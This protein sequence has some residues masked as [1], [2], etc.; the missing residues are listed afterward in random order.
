MRHPKAKEYAKTY[1]LKHKDKVKQKSKE[2][3]ERN[4][5]AYNLYKQ[6]NRS[7]K[8]LLMIERFSNKCN[9]CQQSFPPCVYDFHHFDPSQ[10]DINIGNKMGWSLKRLMKELDKCIMLCA[11]CH[12]IRHNESTD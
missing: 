11:N 1:Y 4:K 6:A 12:R 5:T 3:W 10:K 2:W 9:D 8:K 7:Q